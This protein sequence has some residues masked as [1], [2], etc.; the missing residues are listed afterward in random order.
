MKEVLN[1]FLGVDRH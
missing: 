1:S